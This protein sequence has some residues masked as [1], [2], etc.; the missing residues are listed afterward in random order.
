MIRWSFQIA[1]GH[2]G[3]IG[4][5]LPGVFRTAGMK[6]AVGITKC[7]AT[8]IITGNT[9]QGDAFVVDRPG[10]LSKLKFQ[11]HSNVATGV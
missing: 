3:E 4:C 5:R 1:G 7:C 2:L 11:I 8:A 10:L 6:K 9:I